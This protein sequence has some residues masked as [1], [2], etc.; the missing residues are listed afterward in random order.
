[1]CSVAVVSRWCDADLKGEVAL[2]YRACLHSLSIYLNVKSKQIGSRT[3][4]CLGSL[5][6]PNRRLPLTIVAKGFRPALR[7]KQM[8]RECR[9]WGPSA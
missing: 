5:I 3:T 6:K 4:D 7:A 2:K 9:T 8:R 1:M